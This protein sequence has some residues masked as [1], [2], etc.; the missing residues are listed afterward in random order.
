MEVEVDDYK[1]GAVYNHQTNMGA[2]QTNMG[3]NPHS[4]C[5]LGNISSFSE[6]VPYLKKR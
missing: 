5:D 4:A 2:N 3:S 1:Q 6:S